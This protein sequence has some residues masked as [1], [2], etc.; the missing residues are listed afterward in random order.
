MYIVGT[1][2]S[3]GIPAALV[4]RGR[5]IKNCE[6]ARLSLKNSALALW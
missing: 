2:K 6:R 4:R 5:A 1:A 3:E